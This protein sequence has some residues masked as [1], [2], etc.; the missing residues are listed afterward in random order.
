MALAVFL[1]DL[2][3]VRDHVA[4][5]LDPNRVADIDVFL[6]DLLGVVEARPRD[7]DA[8]DVDRLEQ[9]DGSQSAGSADL[10]RHVDDGRHFRAGRE[11]VGE[12]VAVVTGRPAEFLAGLAVVDLD[13]GAVDLVVQFVTALEHAVAVVDGRVDVG[14]EFDVIGHPQPQSGNRSSSAWWVSA[15]SLAASTSK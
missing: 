14:G 12:G 9:G 8:A 10:N 2:L 11:L 15:S 5:T 7:G 6:G 13:H 1:D 3:D 4:R